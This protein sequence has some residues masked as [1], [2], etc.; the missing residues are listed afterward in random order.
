ML[1]NHPELWVPSLLLVFS[2]HEE[3]PVEK[4]E[5]VLMEDPRLGTSVSSIAAFAVKLRKSFEENQALN[6]SE[7]VW[8]SKS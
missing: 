6:T 4:M 5:K 1:T 8:K 3:A 7:H 2:S